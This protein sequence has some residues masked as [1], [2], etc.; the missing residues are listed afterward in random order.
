M[1]YFITLSFGL[2]LYYV[3]FAQKTLGKQAT[4]GRYSNNVLYYS[5]PKDGGLNEPN[6]RTN[7]KLP[8]RRT[9]VPGKCCNR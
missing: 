9:L 1:K 3:S 6:S 5:E 4:V 8:L 7:I 2:L